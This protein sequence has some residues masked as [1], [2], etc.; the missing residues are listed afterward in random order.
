MV[1]LRRYGFSPDYVV[2]FIVLAGRLA[3]ATTGRSRHTKWQ[4]ATTT[5]EINS[6]PHCYCVRGAA[7]A[8]RCGGGGGAPRRWGR[9]WGIGGQLEVAAGADRLRSYISCIDSLRR[10]QA[11]LINLSHIARR[12]GPPASHWHRAHRKHHRTPA[13]VGVGGGRQRAVWG[14]ATGVALRGA[15]C[16]TPPHTLPAH[17]PPS[18]PALRRGLPS[19]A[20]DMHDPRYAM[21][22]HH[23]HR[24][25]LMR[26]STRACRP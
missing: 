17:T 16:T 26:V 23:G 21:H 25:C 7:V 4:A 11:A 22:L 3:H 6:E 2:R 15:R 5:F 9:G 20:F 12:L 19:P 1:F 24:P 8:A 13:P 18:A 10:L 14:V